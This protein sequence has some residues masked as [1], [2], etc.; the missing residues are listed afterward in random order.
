MERARRT[1]E[2]AGFG[3][4]AVVEPLLSEWDYGDYEG[5]TTPEIRARRPGWDL[6]SDGCPGGE[7]AAD[8]A[9][10]A[11]E[12]LGRLRADDA[13][14][15]KEVLLFSH[16]HFSRVLLVRWL[17]LEPVEARHFELDA[18][19]IGRLGW[20]REWPTAERWNC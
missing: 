1:C 14:V 5:L 12:L 17:G 3:P 19:R 16:G 2:L 13:L 7:G 10:R 9:S 8:V 11:D 20:E 4:V 18:G 6:F 15:G